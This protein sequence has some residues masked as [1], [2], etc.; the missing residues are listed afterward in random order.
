MPAL[1]YTTLLAFLT[2]SDPK[3]ACTI[4]SVF[5]RWKP[6]ATHLAVAFV[7]AIDIHH[8]PSPTTS[9]RCI[10]LWAPFASGPPQLPRLPSSPLCLLLLLPSTPTLVAEHP[11]FQTSLSLARN[12]CRMGTKTSESEHHPCLPRSLRKPRPDT[13]VQMSA[14]LVECCACN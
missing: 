3:F 11:S 1:T 9:R 2:F 8:F 4:S 6:R 7:S 10:L 5:L 14:Q 13:R 12:L